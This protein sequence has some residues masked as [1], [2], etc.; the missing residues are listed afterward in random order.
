M[1]TRHTGLSVPG[2]AA[3]QVGVLL[4]DESISLGDA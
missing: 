1:T 4:A 3:G 2:P